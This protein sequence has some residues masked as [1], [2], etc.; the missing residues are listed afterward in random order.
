MT[1]LVPLAPHVEGWATGT[2]FRD[3]MRHLASGVCLVTSGTLL[4]PVGLVA[5]A[6]CS[7][8][9]E[10]ATLMVSINNAASAFGTIA[11]TGRIVVNV[12]GEQHRDLVEQFSRPERRAERFSSRSWLGEQGGPPRLADALAV[13]D[14]RVV[15]THA[16]FTHTLFLAR[17]IAVAVTTG[18][19][20][21]HYNRALSG[22]AAMRPDDGKDG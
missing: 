20:L 2:A 22:L 12:L 6:V 19:P 5:T 14:C 1:A 8:S 10:P 7:I 17:P 15:E 11:E 4:A 3:G 21:I 13:F 18:E 9:V 16:Y